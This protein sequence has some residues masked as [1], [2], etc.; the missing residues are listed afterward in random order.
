MRRIFLCA[1][2]VCF[3]LGVLSAFVPGRARA[4][5]DPNLVWKTITTPHFRISYYS[6][7]EDIAKHLADEA[8]AI[9]ARLSP[10][11]NWS[12][13]EKV[14]VA[15]FDQTD[16]ANG[17]TSI[18]PY[19]AIRLFVTA[20]DDLSPL[21]DYD[22]WY[23][24]LFTHE[25]T[26]TLHIDQ[27]RGLPALGNALIGK[28]FSP[29]Q[30]Q[31]RW[32]I[33]GLAVYE[34]SVRTSGGRLRSSQWQMFMRAD[35]LENN[36]APLDQFTGTPRRWPQGNIWY[37]YGSFFMKWIQETYGEGVMR[38]VIDDFGQQVIPLGFN[39]SLRRAIGKTY[40]ELY[41]EWIASMKKGFGAQR[42]AI[43]ARGLRE[44]VRLTYG[45]NVA[46]HPVW[47]PKNAWADHQ[48]GLVYFRD[49]G[50]TTPG[51][52]AIDVQRDAR[53]AVVA[54]DDKK[55]DLVIR[56]NGVSHVTFAPDG[57]AIFDS[58]APFRRIFNFTDLFQLP[59]GEKS[60]TGLDGKR[61]RLTQGFRAS[62][63][64]LSPD[65]RRIVFTTNHRGTR[66]LQIADVS[67]E[68]I[69]NVRSLVRSNRFEQAFAPEWSPDNRHV[70]YSVWT[71]GGFRDI[72]Y[73]DTADGT[74]VELAHDRAQD[75]GPSFSPDGR[76]IFFHSDRTGVSNIFAWNVET[77]ELKQVTNVINGAYQPEVSPD[78]KTLAYLGYTH[79]GFDIFAMPLREGDWLDAEP[80]VNTRP[81]PYPPAPHVE[82]PWQ[83]YN[84]LHT[85]RPRR[86]GVSITPGNFGQAVIVTA[87]G[88]DIAGHHAFAASMTTE[89]ERPY[90]QF[91][92]GYT[93]A[94]LPV[95]LNFNVSRS[96]APRGGYQLGQNYK[97][98]WI[99]E[100]LSFSTGISYNLPNS[101]GFD[102]QSFALNY[103]VT[104]LGGELP[105]PA[106][107]LDPYETPV[108]P[109]DRFMLATL[110]LG[111]GY[112]NAQ[113]FLYSVGAEKGF[114]LG[115]NFDFTNT[116]IASDYSGFAANIDFTSYHLMP[117]LAHHSLA[118]HM[119]TGLSG[120]SFPGRGPFYVGGF[121]DLP[122]L[123][124]VRNTLIQGG[125]ALR[126]YPPVILAGRNYALFN[127]EYR[128]PIV[129]I[130]R[131]FSTLPLF[132]KRITGTAFLDYGSAFDDA[133]TAQFK[134]GAG[135]ELWIDTL[136]AYVVDFTFR[137]GYAKGLASG[138]LDKFYFVA[139][140]P[141]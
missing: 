130:D 79:V 40:E 63:P 48:G 38:Q 27:I 100:A 42:D 28:R 132:F 110:H 26:H 88:T 135:G 94:R 44:G 50:H 36:I 61:T 60:P 82:F 87:D 111:W 15:L 55:R 70:A 54:V 73:V 99:Q 86:F 114:S 11:L 34:E 31:P 137:L 140:V 123:D 41:P 109:N 121:V 138:G 98:I 72:R 133:A 12:P 118:L 74:Y 22:G 49:D 102:G 96:I 104:R 125:I 47:I 1:L 23:T 83:S 58:S 90:L 3:T 37:L 91:G 115:A 25:Y 43:V 35:I 85:L 124:I 117:W 18:V 92:L 119:G 20:P 13:A 107:K 19:N 136:M 131:G 5:N 4:A 129:N 128:F 16:G 33:E 105:M 116:A 59:P 46:Q 68:G 89:V 45:G 39:R 112:S 67:D 53:G 120:G 97:P 84:P 30:V 2:F 81:A 8:E 77:A 93:Y 56:T 66:Y 95:D 6:G 10:V 71:E 122:L 106:D 32:F 57:S 75:G 108:I 141:F 24:T 127:A 78:G 126:G 64:A 14:E 113:R 65:G 7:E 69:T 21:S 51:L 17:F 29:N 103:G 62:D 52:Y 9:H 139:T 101:S 134:T 76:W 80:Y